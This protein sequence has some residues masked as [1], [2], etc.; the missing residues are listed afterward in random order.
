MPSDKEIAIAL[1]FG[2]DALVFLKMLHHWHLPDFDS[3]AGSPQT[4]QAPPIL[5]KSA[6]HQVQ[7]GL[8][9]PVKKGANVLEPIRSS[10]SGIPQSR[11]C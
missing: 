8:S 7:A 9:V 2:A 5:L 4:P 10:T 6:S 3:L 11:R 1:R